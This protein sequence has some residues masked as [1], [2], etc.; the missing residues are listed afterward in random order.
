MKRI[1]KLIGLFLVVISL[2]GCLNL[3][4]EAGITNEYTSYLKYDL[5]MDLDAV[6][7]SIRNDISSYI[8]EIS[9]SYEKFGF[10]ILDNGTKEKIDMTFEYQLTN[11]NYDDAIESLKKMLSNPKIS[12]LTSVDITGISSST[13]QAINFNAK[14]DLKAIL[15]TTNYQALPISIANIIN[16]ALIEGKATFVLGLPISNING[17]NTQKITQERMTYLEYDLSLSE[18]STID[19]EAVTSLKDGKPISGDTSTV[20]NR[21]KKDIRTYKIVIFGSV[22]LICVCIFL[23][24]RTKRQRNKR[25]IKNQSGNDLNSFDTI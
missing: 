12:F 22:V 13:Q 20:I 10:E 8:I 14:T 7:S 6:D 1:I 15:D 18:E 23:L 17:A 16:Q 24:I 4:M 11:L 21:F 5:K 19:A 9:E 2:S 3:K 25:S